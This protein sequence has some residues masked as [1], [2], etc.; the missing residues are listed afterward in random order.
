VDNGHWAKRGDMVDIFVRP[1]RVQGP[2]VIVV[3]GIEILDRIEHGNEQELTLALPQREVT[4]VEKALQIGKLS[5]ALIGADEKKNGLKKQR[6]R[7][8]FQRRSPR[9]EVLNE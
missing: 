7:H 1:R 6:A 5:I 4:V 3:E 8:T 2:P 9:V